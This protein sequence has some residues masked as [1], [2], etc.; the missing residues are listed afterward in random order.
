[1]AEARREIV[2]VL[3][4]AKAASIAPSRRREALR[5]W[6]WGE[7][8][9]VYEPHTALEHPVDGS[10]WYCGAVRDLFSESI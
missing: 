3:T 10:I 8:L 2:I 5:A 9:D 1:V 6:A 7:G 4:P